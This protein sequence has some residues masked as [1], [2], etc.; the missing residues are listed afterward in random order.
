MSND[1]DN[2]NGNGRALTTYQPGGALALNTLE[3]LSRFGKVLYESGLFPDVKSQAQ[4]I[5]KIMVAQE[6]GIPPMEGMMGIDVVQGKA[7]LSAN[8]MARIIK[9]DAERGG[10]DYR[11]LRLDNQ[12]CEIRFFHHGQPLEPISSF[13]IDDAK[14]AKLIG[15]DIYQAYPRNMLF[16][17]ALTNGAKWHCPHLFSGATL[18]GESNAELEEDGEV[19]ISA[20]TPPTMEQVVQ[21]AERNT[22][23]PKDQRAASKRFNTPQPDRAAVERKREQMFGEVEA[24]TITSEPAE[25]APDAGQIAT[26]SSAV[27]DGA[28][29]NASEPTGEPVTEAEVETLGRA[30]PEEIMA[31]LTR[32][33]DSCMKGQELPWHDDPKRRATPGRA[34]MDRLKLHDYTLAESAAL[35]KAL[36]FMTTGED[37]PIADA[38]KVV[39]A[40][41][42]VALQELPTPDMEALLP[43]ARWFLAREK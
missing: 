6:L 20:P 38:G 17:R 24:E 22:A 32:L 13:T 19:V 28:S 25:D 36:H 33:R 39:S 37:V 16:A 7:R 12:A 9:R 5:V 27:P 43:A 35:F 40:R 18:A 3:D 1:N 31:P 41:Y 11:I 4:A 8:M 42:L 30:I 10:Y 26:P 34:C 23:M 29:E 2:G 21:E 15:K 14:Q